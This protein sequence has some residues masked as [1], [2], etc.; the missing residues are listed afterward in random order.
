M[1]LVLSVDHRIANGAYAAQ[2]LDHFR[3]SRS[4]KRKSYF[5]GDDLESYYC[6]AADSPVQMRTYDKGKEM[7]G[8]ADLTGQ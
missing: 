2:F 5:D 1:A 3:V 6:G 8:Q 7:D 4:C